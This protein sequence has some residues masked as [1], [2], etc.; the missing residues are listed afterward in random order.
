MFLDDEHGELEPCHADHALSQEARLQKLEEELDRLKRQ[1]FRGNGSGGMQPPWRHD[2]S[3]QRDR[4]QKESR[5]R[6]SSSDSARSLTP[7]PVGDGDGGMETSYYELRRIVPHLSPEFECAERDAVLILSAIRSGAAAEGAES[8][9]QRLSS[10]EAEKR[11]IQG[12]LARR[13][14]EC[15]ALK[16]TVAELRQKIRATQEDSHAS[17]NLLSKRNEEVRKQL[18]LEESRS[19][20]MKIRNGQLEME[21]ERLRGLLHSHLHK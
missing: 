1:Q 17:V 13:S 19:Q 8:W 5:P 18:L 6:L 2:Y 15:E 7:S 12:R 21:V 3:P 11:M 9:E 16:G 10:L 14:Q 20:K 4:R